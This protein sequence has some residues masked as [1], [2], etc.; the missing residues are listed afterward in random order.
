MMIGR[1]RIDGDLALR[2]AAEGASK[3]S[4]LVMAFLLARW[5]ATEGFGAYAQTMALVAVLVPVMLLG[6]GFA[7]VRQIA[8]SQ[9]GLVRARNHPG[10]GAVVE[11][12]LPRA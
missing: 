9:G 2:F 5:M 3:G 1:H 8:L 11:L 4:A 10:G 7:I 12:L 6:L